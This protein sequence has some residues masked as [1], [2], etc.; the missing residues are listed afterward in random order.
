MNILKKNY[1]LTIGCVAQCHVI[2]LCYVQS[3]DNFG[4]INCQSNRWLNYFQYEPLV[5]LLSL[6]L[7]L[8]LMKLS[9]E[10]WVLR[11]TCV[12]QRASAA[13][14]ECLCSVCVCCA[15]CSITFITYEFIHH[16]CWLIKSVVS[17][18]SY[19]EILGVNTV[20]YCV[21]RLV[22]IKKMNYEKTEVL[23]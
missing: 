23:E 7:L 12:G 18:S 14:C 21:L 11:C 5:K 10:V 19:S 20:D 15:V 2:G 16:F 13:H 1:R 22:I 4:S 17:I 3:P 9:C 6:D 8:L